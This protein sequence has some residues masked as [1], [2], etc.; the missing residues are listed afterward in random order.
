MQKVRNGGGERKPHDERCWRCGGSTE[1][2]VGWG[3]ATKAPSEGALKVK[4]ER[5]TKRKEK[6]EPYHSITEFKLKSISLADKAQRKKGL[7]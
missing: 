5:K 7:S 6:N 2:C 3:R 1:V 4:S